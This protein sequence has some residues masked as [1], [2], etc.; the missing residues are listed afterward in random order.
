M[1]R[2]TPDESREAGTTAEAGGAEG[3]RPRPTGAPPASARANDPDP[4]VKVFRRRRYLT[5]SFKRRVVSE[6]TRLRSQGFGAVGSYLRSVG[7]YYSSAAQWERLIRDGGLSP[8]RGNKQ[9]SRDS[10]LR[11]IHRLRR[12]VK[13]TERKLQQSELIIELQKK[14]SAVAEMSLGHNCEGSK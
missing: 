1:S 6:I 12:Q 10:L 8:A 7:V 2:Q 14:I 5:D 4:E 9:Q 13:D 11:E 3:G